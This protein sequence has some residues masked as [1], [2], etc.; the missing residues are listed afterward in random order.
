M[1]LIHLSLFHRLLS[2]L[3]FSFN[4][5]TMK[6]EIKLIL[7]NK[8]CINEN[9]DVKLKRKLLKAIVNCNIEIKFVVVY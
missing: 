1:K 9:D 4:C 8:K 5:L 3:G 2:E 7:I 6:E